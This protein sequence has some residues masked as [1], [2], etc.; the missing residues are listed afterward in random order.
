[1]PKEKET[2]KTEPPRRTVEEWR[3][4]FNTPTWLFAAA[5]AKFGWPVAAELT[6]AEYQKALK[7]TE[8]EV[9]R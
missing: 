8:S 4:L 7:A 6:E 5:R 3:D 1:M 9:I 2:E